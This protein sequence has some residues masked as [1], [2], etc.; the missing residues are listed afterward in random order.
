M[1]TNWLNERAEQKRQDA[2]AA[3]ARR[4]ENARTTAE[5]DAIKRRA[6]LE[7]QQLAAEHADKRRR[8]QRKEQAREQA[9]RRARR[10]K[11]F[12]DLRGWATEHMSDL[13]IYPLAIVSAVMAIPAMA[14]YGNKVYNGGTGA[15]LPVITELGMW[16]FAFSVQYNRL[17]HPERPV[18]ALVLG[19][20]T[21]ATVGAALNYLDG[22]TAEG[23]SVGNGIVMGVVS[24]AGVVAHQLVSASPRRSAAERDDL[25]VRRYAAKKIA[26]ARKAV[27]DASVT[28]VD[29]SGDVVLMFR[30]GHYN[31]TKRT[32]DPIASDEPTTDTPVSD[33]DRALAET[34]ERWNAETPTGTSTGAPTGGTVLAPTAP[35][36]LAPIV[37]P[38][39][40]PESS[41][42]QQE[43]TPTG[44]VDR[45]DQS[46]P[47]RGTGRLRSRARRSGG[48]AP[49]R[50][51]RS[52]AEL[53]DDLRAAVEAGTVD[54]TSAESI[55][56]GLN[57]GQARARELRDNPNG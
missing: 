57:V 37:T 16:A 3:A 4:R 35:P 15:A 47:S 28:R 44:R 51:S 30:P 43:S 25:R 53:R 29:T 11:L 26:A 45:P 12:K 22:A 9:D 50:K 56:K 10:G 2:D 54:P 31:L 18:W 7:A 36:T 55:R 49:D 24:V 48:D 33:V 42:D 52:I 40:D 23:G 17:R 21:F 8:D 32:L 41:G 34:V 20:W 13:M 5:V 27:I 14:H 46:T 6:D 19:V 38:P 39:V 1:A